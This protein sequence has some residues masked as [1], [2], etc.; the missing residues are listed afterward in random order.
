MPLK[1]IN[2]LHALQIQAGITGRNAG[3]QFEQAIASEIN[4][5]R[6]PCTVTI[7]S[8]THI[9]CG[10]PAQIL[11]YYIGKHFG[12][13]SIKHAFAIPTGVLATSEDG[14]AYLE[15]NGTTVY[16]CKSDLILAF[17][18]END[19]DR[20]IGVSIKQCNN[21][22]PTNAQLYFST[23]R[24]FSNLLINNS[25]TVTNNAIIALRQF[26]GD[27]GFR[28]Q[29]NPDLLRGREVDPRR[30]FWEE[31]DPSG[32]NEWERIFATKQ[33]DITRLLLQK[34]YLEDQFVPEFLLHRTKKSENW[35][36]TEVAVYEIE[37]LIALS[38]KYQNFCTKGYAVR[39]GTY[40]DPVGIEH[41]APRFG[42]IQM[43][44]GGQA[45]HP[46]QLQF[47]LEAGYFYKI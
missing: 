30:F 29:D 39:K 1:P 2:H 35:D 6:Y 45:Q 18:D 5:L 38:K 47:N 15:I 22:T 20:T 4:R 8:N 10:N 36:N 25:I 21:K 11:L 33:D 7:G 42:I 19:T 9:Y 37:E 43:Q 12:C 26:C 14:K 27:A 23:A 3:H 41:L 32:R 34:A 16:R 28:P 40:R 46:E 17:V 44:R 13:Q 31:I 24:A